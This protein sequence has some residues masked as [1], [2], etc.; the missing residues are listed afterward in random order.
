MRLILPM[1]VLM[2]AG[3]L[4]A[5]V[6]DGDAS[7][8]LSAPNGRTGTFAPYRLSVRQIDGLET[9]VVTSE[10]QGVKLTREVAVAGKAEVEITLP[11]FVGDGARVNVRG[12]GAEFTPGIEPRLPLR[13]I[14]PDYARPYVAVFSNDPVY[15]RVLVPNAPRQAVSDWRLLDGYDA[16]VIINPGETRLPPGSQQAIA[17]FCSLGGAALVIGSF[18]LGEK[19]VDVPAPAD[20]TVKVVR[21]VAVQRFGYGPGAIYRIGFDELQ[22]SRTAP[23]VVVDALRDHLWFGADSA[24]GGKPQSRVPPRLTPFAPPLPPA[25]AAP[26]AIFW[27]LGGGVLLL[28]LLAP[29]IGSRLT[30]RA[31]AAQLVVAAGC[32]GLGALGLAQDRPLPTVELTAVIR[33]GESEVASSR[34]FVLA[35]DSWRGTLEVELGGADRVLPRRVP[36]IA[37]WH[38]WAIDRPLVKLPAARGEQAELSSGMVGAEIFRDYATRAHRQGTQFSTSDAYPLEWWL[39]QNAYRG[40]MAKLAPLEW[41]GEPIQ[42]DDARVI[43]RGAIG[44]TVK[45]APG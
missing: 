23:D 38:A 26:T 44:V 33:S 39:E 22:R 17:E 34:T 18:R 11:V 6:I 20:P 24:P 29:V 31:W 30:K 43:E 10:A 3:V 45:R 1:L 41:P 8:F 4:P 21:G 28:C 2:L 15:A 25:E 36:G 16:I 9:L 32:A 7:R 14:E 12:K 13:R 42:L 35:E 40:H 27:G 37:G 19:D 5:Q